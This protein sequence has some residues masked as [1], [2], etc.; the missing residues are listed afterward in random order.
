MDDEE[1]ILLFALSSINSVGAH[2][3]Q[4]IIKKMGSAKKVY[5][6][7]KGD[8]REVISNDKIISAIL[9]KE[10][11][12]DA[13]KLFLE[14][15]KKGVKIVSYFDDDYPERLRNVNK[16]PCFLFVAGE[17]NLNSRRVLSVIGTR[18]PS[19]Y[20][21]E[22]TAKFLEGLSE[23]GVVLISGLAYGIDVIAHKNA[24]KYGMKTAA[25]IAGGVDR[26]Y[27]A[28]HKPIAEEMIKNGGC[29][30]SESP[31]G[32]EPERY[33]FPA[34]NRIIA[35]CSDAVLII[36]AGHKSG[37]IITAICANDFN[38]EVFAV[39]GDV[40]RSTSVGCNNLIKKNQAQLVTS[41][42]DIVMMMN[43]K[44]K[45]EYIK[46]Q[47]D[48]IEADGIANMG[49]SGFGFKE[50]LAGRYEDLYASLNEKE[51]AIVNVLLCGEALFFDEIVSKTHISTR[52]LSFLLLNMEFRDIL[53]NLPG[54]KY[55]LKNINM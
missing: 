27:P 14:H 3:W 47:D 44:D 4:E 20:G 30:V 17:N 16:P 48:K 52:E 7:A 13:E 32:T 34:R 25:I 26:I 31:L 15:K 22:N 37:T 42:E 1:R 38:R 12:E 54:N 35:G 8:L 21:R 24:L 39:P 5:S 49:K 2:L 40:N 43:W 53:I 11:V 33:L 36:E 18:Y 10:G 29:V 51:R 9:E 23:Y 45:I 55:K 28:E 50:N 6:S 46:V 41:P 19:S